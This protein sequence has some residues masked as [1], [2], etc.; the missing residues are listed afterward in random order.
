MVQG[1]H[2][3]M[4]LGDREGDDTSGLDLEEAVENKLLLHLKPDNREW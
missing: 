3:A 1:S 2:L 4:D